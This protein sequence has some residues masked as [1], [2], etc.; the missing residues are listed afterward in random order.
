MCVAADT[1]CFRFTPP[2]E[3]DLLLIERGNDP[4]KGF[5][6]L[7]GG[8][9]DIDEDLPNAA[10]R[11]LKEETGLEPTVIEQ[12]GAWGRP[13]RDPRGRTVS[14]VYLAT[15]Q[16]GS[17]GIKG[18]D[19]ANRAEWHPLDR[20]PSLAFDHT[21]IASE[22]LKKL[23]KDIERTHIAFSLLKE[24]FSSEQLARLIRALGGISPENASARLIAA[25][26]TEIADKTEDKYKMIDHDFLA[27]LAEPVF[28]FPMKVF[29]YTTR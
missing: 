28:V 22:A 3:V 14:V 2:D 15:A 8:F 16:P 11:E 27:P 7:P 6:A 25:G 13:G 10:A 29:G 4:Q 21:D 5:W 9:V 17:D 19:D 1:V 24:E 12:V 26:N 20:L 23:R 18:G